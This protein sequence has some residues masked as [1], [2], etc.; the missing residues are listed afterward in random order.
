[1]NGRL[2]RCV[3]ADSVWRD[4]PT[5]TASL[6]ITGIPGTTTAPIP[7]LNPATLALLALALGGLALRQ[8]RRGA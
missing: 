6:S 5:S 7:V 4:A 1:M 3:V 2:F 8:R